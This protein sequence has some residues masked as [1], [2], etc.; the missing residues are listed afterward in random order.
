[1][2]LVTAIFIGFLA[3]IVIGA[4]NGALPSLVKSLYSFPGG[5]KLGHFLLMGTLSLLVNIS[6]RA[7]QA[8]LF[9]RNVLLGSAIVFALVTLEEVSQSWFELRTFSLIDLGFD[10]GGILSGGRLASLMS[11]RRRA[12][13]MSKQ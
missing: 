7:R 4:D 1:M 9:S 10:Y 13:I 8:R 6:L 2:K 3:A 5:D 11:R 12:T